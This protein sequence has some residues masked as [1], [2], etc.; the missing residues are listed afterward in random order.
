[1]VLSAIFFIIANPIYS[2]NMEKAEQRQIEYENR[3]KEETQQFEESHENSFYYQLLTLEIDKDLYRKIYNS[4]LN[5]NMS[6]GIQSDFDEVFQIFD[7]VLNDHPELFWVSSELQFITKTK[8][9]NEKQYYINFQY[10][11]ED[12]LKNVQST[13]DQAVNAC[14][15]GIQPED[16]EY[17]KVEYIYNYLLKNMQYKNNNDQSIYSSLVNKEGVCAGY[18]RTFQYILNRVGIKATVVTGD[19]KTT[20]E[21]TYYSEMLYSLQN[22]NS[23]ISY[24]HMWNMIKI[25][26][27]WLHYDLTL[28]DSHNDNIQFFGLT[29]Q[30]IEQTHI[31][32]LDIE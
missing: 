6:L 1:M 30:Q 22:R 10:Q 28:D 15:S 29:T 20:Q 3:Q 4:V 13:I 12:E 21:G 11:Y 5:K 25:G 31:I 23:S 8:N 27:E 24:G 2:K 16:N 14:L 9:A 17:E 32:D 18:S 19:L 26:D 7:F